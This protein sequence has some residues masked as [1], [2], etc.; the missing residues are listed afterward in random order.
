MKNS[1]FRYVCLVVA[2]LICS[3]ADAQQ[4]ANYKLAEKFRLLEQNPIIKYSTEVKPTFIN[5]TDCFYYSFTTR[6]GKKYYYVNPKKKEKR[7]LF[8]TAELLSKIAVYTKKAYSSADPYLSFTFMKD[9]ETIRI[10]FDRGL[11]TYNIHT[12]ALKQ[13]NEKASYG[14][15]L[16]FVGNQKKGQDTIPVQLTTDGE[17]NYT[18]NREDEGKLEGRFGAESTHW[19][20]GSHRFYA[21]REDNRKVRD[22]WLIRCLLHIRH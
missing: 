14:N 5:G 7:L 11:Y 2:L 1:L 18:F 19:I 15:N 22:L 4:K 6:E 12:K 17:P 8:D 21:V 9:N 16:Y 3:F 20:P 10:D 13:L